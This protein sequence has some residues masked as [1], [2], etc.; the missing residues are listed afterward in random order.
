MIDRESKLIFLPGISGRALMVYVR[1][2]L[3]KKGSDV[4]SVSPRATVFE[5]LEV[6]AEHNV[7]A[8]LV[9]DEGKLAGVFSERD[10]ARKVI[11]QGRA[12]K[13]TLV[14][15]LM[16]RGVFCVGLSDDINTCMAIMTLQRIRHL[17]V[18]DE[19]GVVGVISIGDVVKETIS[20]QK[21]TI[22]ELKKYIAGSHGP[23]IEAD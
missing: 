13:D 11:L 7:G 4:R 1:D 8:V 17:P 12:S 23:E 18:L 16:E 9:L 2:I 20:D 15:E 19:G 21:F 6:M 14:S 22:R 3:R 10:Y 5:A